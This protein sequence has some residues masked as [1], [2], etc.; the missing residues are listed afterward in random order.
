[1]GEELAHLPEFV[2]SE[3]DGLPLRKAQP[4]WALVGRH[5][6]EA[7]SVRDFPIRLAHGV[8]CDSFTLQ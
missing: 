1:M 7:D 4:S 5:A 2:I 6:G 8:I 3:G